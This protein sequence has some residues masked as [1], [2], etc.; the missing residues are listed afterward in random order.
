MG[1]PILDLS[2]PLATVVR[3]VPTTG[4]VAAMTEE[5]SNGAPQ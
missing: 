4:R 3:T 1:R 5:V 2:H